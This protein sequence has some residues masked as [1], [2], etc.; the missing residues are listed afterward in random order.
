MLSDLQKWFR[1]ILN[2]PATVAS[3]AVGVVVFAL[4]FDGSLFQ[5]WTLVREK[6]RLEQTIVTTEAQTKELKQK[7][8]QAK[9]LD[10]IDKKTKI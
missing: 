8:R 2:S 5:Y 1:D 7:I 10:F 3:Y 4:I 6:T 9:S